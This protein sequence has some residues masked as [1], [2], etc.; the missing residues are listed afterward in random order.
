MGVACCVATIRASRPRNNWQSHSDS[1]ELRSAA[2]R[3]DKISC[4]APW[5][6]SDPGRFRR[7]SNL[8]RAWTQRVE[9]LLSGH[10]YAG[11]AALGARREQN[12]SQ[13][14]FYSKV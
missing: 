14:T 4:G 13:P 3:I 6:C 2:S 1:A 7:A 10:E 5:L 9:S 8:P 11:K 12:A